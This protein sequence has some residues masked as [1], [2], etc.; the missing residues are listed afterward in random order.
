MV[1]TILVYY[2]GQWVLGGHVT[3]ISGGDSS[4]ALQG[5]G[6]W[7]GGSGC[8]PFVAGRS[9]FGCVCGLDWLE[10]DLYSISLEGITYPCYLLRLAQALCPSR[11][12]PMDLR[13]IV[14]R[15][16]F[17]GEYQFYFIFFRFWFSF[18]R[19]LFSSN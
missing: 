12:F 18:S 8:F 17:C 15:S 19:F 14:R 10:I 9:V 7:G 5:V 11:P 13:M 6:F 3:G 1:K 2:A 4:V 16:I